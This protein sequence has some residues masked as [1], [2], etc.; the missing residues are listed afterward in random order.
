MNIDELAKKI[1]PAQ[2]RLL[3][4]DR[5]SRAAP[6]G[7]F[8]ECGVYMGRSACVLINACENKRDVY[9]CDGFCGFPE[10]T[11]EDIFPEKYHISKGSHPFGSEKV[12]EFITKAG[13]SLEKVHF[14]KGFFNQT[15]GFLAKDID[16]IAVLHFD[17]DC[18]EAF[19][20]VF[21]ELM[22]KVAKGGYLIIHDYPGF[23][24]V[25]KAVDE[26]IGADKLVIEDFDC[27]YYKKE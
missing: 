5:I 6:E 23:P 8:V 26:L 17:A 1:P 10:L 24:G 2:S 7:A 11:K 21:K 20:T 14:I 4:L 19:K 12:K 27:V 16:K 18:Y 25:K 13:V 3:F 9:L 15:L 22:P